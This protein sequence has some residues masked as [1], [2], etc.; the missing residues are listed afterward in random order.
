MFLFLI[1]QTVNNGYDSY[2]SAIVVAKDA[3]E[4]SKIH[5]AELFWTGSKWVPG[6][7]RGYYSSDYNWANPKDVSAT[8]I[9]VADKKFDRPQVILD[10]YRSG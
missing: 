9:G 1:E 8:L 6:D 5:P 4:A 3:D 7:G 2:L 10:S